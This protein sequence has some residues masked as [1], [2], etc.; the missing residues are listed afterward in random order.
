MKSQAK[1]ST[2]GRRTDAKVYPK[3]C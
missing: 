1:N 2:P 3:H